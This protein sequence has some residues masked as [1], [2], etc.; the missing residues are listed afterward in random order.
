MGNDEYVDVKSPDIEIGDVTGIDV[1]EIDLNKHTLIGYIE[2][3][4]DW[5]RGLV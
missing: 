2:T 3:I 5:I 4:I 1:K